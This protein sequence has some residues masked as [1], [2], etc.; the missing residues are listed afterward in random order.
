MISLYEVE[1]IFFLFLIYAFSG[2]A[3]ETGNELIMSKKFVNRGFLIRTN[4]P[5]IWYWSGFD[6]TRTYKI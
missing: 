2:W 3:I 4:L 5:Y 6:F 1:K